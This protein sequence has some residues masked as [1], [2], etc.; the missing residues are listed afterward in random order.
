MISLQQC[1]WIRDVVEVTKQETLNRKRQRIFNSVWL[2][3]HRNHHHGYLN[4]YKTGDNCLVK[5]QI[6]SRFKFK[7]IILSNHCIVV[8]WTLN[9]SGNHQMAFRNALLPACYISSIHLPDLVRSPHGETWWYLNVYLWYSLSFQMPSCFAIDAILHL[10]LVLSTL[11]MTV[12]GLRDEC[13][14]IAVYLALLVEHLGSP[15]W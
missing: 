8:L 3:L 6:M 1:Y 13:L 2:W 5:S 12:R 15:W 10:V 14:I 4:S 11:V 7:F 9:Y